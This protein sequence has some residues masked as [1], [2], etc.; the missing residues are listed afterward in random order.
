MVILLLFA[1]GTDTTLLFLLYGYSVEEVGR[2]LWECSNGPGHQM[3]KTP[4]GR[5]LTKSR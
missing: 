3:S 4:N 5:R 2:V 1:S